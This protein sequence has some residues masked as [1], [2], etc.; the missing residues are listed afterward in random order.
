MYINPKCTGL[1]DCQALWSKSRQFKSSGTSSFKIDAVT[2]HQIL[3][4]PFGGKKVPNKSSSC[5]KSVILK[6]T[7]QQ[8]QAA[9]IDDLIAMI[10][11]Q[12]NGD[13]FVRI[14]LLVALGIFLCPKSSATVSHQFYESIYFVKGIRDYDWCSSVADCLHLGV[15]NFQNNAMKGNSIGKATL[16]GCLFVLVVSTN[17]FLLNN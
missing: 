13:K 3:G 14:F 11:P 10:T 6:D 8:N 16:G 17:P 1:M 4:I 15:M 2:V 7:N 9:K 12:L 5:A